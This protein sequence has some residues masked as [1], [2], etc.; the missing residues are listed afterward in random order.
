M[1]RKVTRGFKGAALRHVRENHPTL[2]H[3]GELA[4][5]AG[6]SK[7]AVEQWEREEKSPSVKLLWRVAQALGVPM[8]V[9]VPI[10]VTERYLGDWRVLRGM[11]Q[12]E[13]ATAAGLSAPT[14]HRLELGQVALSRESATGLAEGLGLS[15]DEV[16]AAY[17]RARQRPPGSPA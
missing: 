5:V 6:V 2:H 16:R 13:L 12:Q 10:P 7:S 9:L 11:T 4:R 3:T 14:V 8:D 15:V 17:E 1:T